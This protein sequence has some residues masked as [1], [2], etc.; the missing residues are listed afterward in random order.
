[1]SIT[2]ICSSVDSLAIL[3][4]NGEQLCSS[5]TAAAAAVS[6][7]CFESAA[8]MIVI[9][10]TVLEHFLLSLSAVAFLTCF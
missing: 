6:A 4:M 3:M 1:M 8:L 2:G 5:F 7:E 10:L 9:H